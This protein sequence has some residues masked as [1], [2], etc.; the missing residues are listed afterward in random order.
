MTPIEFTKMIT[1]LNADEE[2]TS[3]TLGVIISIAKKALEPFAQGITVNYNPEHY[4][5]VPINSTADWVNALVQDGWN[6]PS[7]TIK[8]IVNFAPPLSTL[9][10]TV[11]TANFVFNP[12]KDKI[13]EPIFEQKTK[14]MDRRET[15]GITSSEPLA[16]AKTSAWSQQVAGDH[17]KV[18]PLQPMEISMRNKLNPLQHTIMKYVFRYPVKNGIEDLKKGRHAID[19]LIEFETNPQMFEQ[20]VSDF[21]KSIESDE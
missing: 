12:V 2:L 17:Y 16:I 21:L 6:N 10:V 4:K 9:D 18:M 5:L 14:V 15:R 20:I 3:L 8:T 7:S 1:R 13:P 19:M 11:M